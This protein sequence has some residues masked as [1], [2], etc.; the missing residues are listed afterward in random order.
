ME[1]DMRLSVL[2]QKITTHESVMRQKLDDLAT[3]IAGVNEKVEKLESQF[4]AI[5][6]LLTRLVAKMG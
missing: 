6:G 4:S 2:E 1:L 5:E 3:S